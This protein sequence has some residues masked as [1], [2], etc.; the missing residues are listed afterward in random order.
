MG[1]GKGNV[2]GWVAPVK[3]GRVLFEISGCNDVVAREALSLA[4]NK[5][6]VRCKSW[7]V[8]RKL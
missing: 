3:A 7:H 2:E 4:A 8:N 6:S 5:L 1:K